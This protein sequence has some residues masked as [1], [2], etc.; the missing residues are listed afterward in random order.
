[1][2]YRL[3]LQY[4]SFIFLLFL[5]GFLRVGSKGEFWSWFD[6]V[7]LGI[8]RIGRLLSYMVCCWT[9]DF[10]ESIHV[11]KTGIK[12]QKYTYTHLVGGQQR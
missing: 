2:V 8:V 10:N 7:L 3:L 6:A 4:I 11:R 12:I 9:N 5:V 1:M